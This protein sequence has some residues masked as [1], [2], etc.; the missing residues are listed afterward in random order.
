[1][2]SE[3][4]QIIQDSIITKQKIFRLVDLIEKSAQ[5]MISALKNGNKIL[6]CGNGGSAADAQHMA[7]EIVGRFEKERRGLPCIALTTDTSILTSL[8]NDYNYETVFSRQVDALG[9]E[10]DVLIGISTSGNSKNIIKSFE[11]AEEKG[12]KSIALTGKDGG[13]ING[14]LE[15]VLNITIP[16]ENTAR[17]QESHL[18]IIHIWCKMIEDELF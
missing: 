13:R 14:M 9:K 17:I 1:M 3:I 11:K 16:S 12:L 4:K 7:G 2:E 15:Y 18:T 8:A 5:I 6:I 10:G